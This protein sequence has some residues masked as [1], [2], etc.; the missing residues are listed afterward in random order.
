MQAYLEQ[1]LSE[2]LF[3]SLSLY[4][5]SLSSLS[6]CTCA[7]PPVPAWAALR[8]PYLPALY[9]LLRLAQL[10]LSFAL[11]AL[12]VAHFIEP[13]VLWLLLV[14]AALLHAT[15]AAPVLVLEGIGLARG[16]P[17]SSAWLQA[18]LHLTLAA[19]ALIPHILALALLCSAHQL[20]ACPSLLAYAPPSAPDWASYTSSSACRYLPAAVCVAAT[21]VGLGLLDLAL[22]AGVIVLD[23][24][25]GNG[26]K[27]W[28]TG[29][30][31]LLW[32][33][34]ATWGQRQAA[35]L[36]QAGTSVG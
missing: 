1:Q 28:T 2:K 31:Q 16:Q 19:L 21:N 14:V 33:L 10:V 6:S 22:T 9:L 23:P 36:D 3:S 26:P 7:A 13:I 30:G 34:E 32:E 20:P 17:V 11:P 25:R 27:R 4:K 5:P 12:L 35:A 29:V 8:R 15:Y 24:A 18:G